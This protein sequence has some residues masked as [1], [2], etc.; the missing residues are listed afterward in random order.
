MLT[1]CRQRRYNNGVENREGVPSSKT[2]IDARS[3][4]TG[5]ADSVCLSYK[6]GKSG[7]KQKRGGTRARTAQ[8]E[9]WEAG[10]GFGCRHEAA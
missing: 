5:A 10:Y 7:N 8:G 4:L 9:R 3:V 6:L 2:H 1:L